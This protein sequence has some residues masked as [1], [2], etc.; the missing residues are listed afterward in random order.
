MNYLYN[1]QQKLSNVFI[2]SNSLMQIK[3]S[4]TAIAIYCYL[5]YLEDRETHECYPSYKTIGEALDISINTV[6]KYVQELEDKQLIYTEY[7]QV[8]LKDGTRRNG[9]LK[10]KIRPITEA[11]EHF[12]QEQFKKLELDAA[13]IKAQKDLEDYD[14][15]HPKASA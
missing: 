6:I 7:T 5:M 10:Y 9:N 15:K 11:V 3:L 13:H 12:Y 8:T 1:Q 14:R 4:T 2:L